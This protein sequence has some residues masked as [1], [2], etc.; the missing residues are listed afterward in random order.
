MLALADYHQVSGNGDRANWHRIQAA[1]IWDTPEHL[2]IF[3]M[4]EAPKH[5]PYLDLIDNILRKVTTEQSVHSLLYYSEMAH[6]QE[7]R[8]KAYQRQLL[9]ANRVISNQ[10]QRTGNQLFRMTQ[11]LAENPD[12]N[13]P[14][15][16]YNRA[17]ELWNR[18]WT[19]VLPFYQDTAIPSISELQRVLNNRDRLL[20]FVEGKSNIGL[21]VVSKENAFAVG[22][23]SKANLQSMSPE[24]QFD[25]LEG[26]L[27]TVWETGDAPLI[28][29]LSPSFQNDVFI[30]NL[31]KRMTR[32]ENLNLQFSL[33]ALI[34]PKRVRSCRKTLIFSSQ[35]DKETGSLVKSLPQAGLDWFF[36]EQ[37]TRKQIE[38]QLQI[39]ERLILS[40]S[41]AYNENGLVF[42]TRTEPFPIHEVIR[43][44]PDL[45]NLTLISSNFKE[46]VSA[47][48]EL[49]MI[50]PNASM[51]IYL[52]RTPEEV[53]RFKDRKFGIYFPQVSQ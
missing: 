43:H 17:L 27:G 32:P 33:K 34:S 9:S 29:R 3:S 4:Q 15:S 47:M 1:Q 39:H 11:S 21:L 25:F 51:T 38:A 46:W 45:C 13:E 8:R 10:I 23:G 2:P 20:T 7:L 5:S 16:N 12:H 19:Q 28:L 35:Q 44:N 24:E 42:E 6:F 18:L 14:A 31:E 52:A 41:F 50:S 49:E 53:E 26:R 22:L 37:A 48:A 30:G 36:G 40:G